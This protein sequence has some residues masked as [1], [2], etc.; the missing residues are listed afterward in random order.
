MLK[1]ILIILILLILTGGCSRMS[2]KEQVTFENSRFYPYYNRWELDQL[3]R[4]ID[5]HKK[6]YGNTQEVIKYSF[7]LTERLEAK[8]KLEALIK[9]VKNEISQ[10]D[11]TTL[12]K[13][14]SKSL[15][16]TATINDIKKLD[17]TRYRLFIS[18]TNFE[19]NTANNIIALNIGEETFYFD[20][21]FEY[22]KGMWEV[23]KFRER[24]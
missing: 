1:K 11:L 19:N 20:V 24:R 2:K 4:E 16:N 7:L 6:N 3:K 14:M 18:K 23:M 15:R 17:F 8:Q 5:E 13:H 9:R 12:K 10:N 22:E 21:E